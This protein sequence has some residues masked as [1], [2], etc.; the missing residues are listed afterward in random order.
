VKGYL[1]AFNLARCPS[2]YFDWC[3]ELTFLLVAS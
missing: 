2:W 1:G 3:L